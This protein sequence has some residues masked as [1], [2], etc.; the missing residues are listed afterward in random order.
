[1]RPLRSFQYIFK[2]PLVA[3]TNNTTRSHRSNLDN[4]AK[5]THSILKADPCNSLYFFTPPCGLVHKSSQIFTSP[6]FRATM[7]LTPRPALECALWLATS[8]RIVLINNQFTPKQLR[9]CSL[10]PAI[11][12]EF[13]GSRALNHPFHRI[14]V[15]KILLPCV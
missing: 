7:T 5:H 3:G 15:Q 12:W 1:M 8:P 13:P 9:K 6:T 10:V 2:P 4:N 14:A 11:S